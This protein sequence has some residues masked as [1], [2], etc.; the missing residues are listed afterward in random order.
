[1]KPL[2]VLLAATLVLAGCEGMPERVA[3]EDGATASAGYGRA[4]GRVHYT[5]GGKEFDWGAF[6]LQTHDLT[7]FVRPLPD[8]PMQFMP[9]EGSGAFV[10]PLRPGDYEIIGLQ[11]RTSS[12]ARS[13]RTASVVARFRVPEAG[14]AVYI[15]DL[16]VRADNRSSHVRV[17]DE[18]EG[19]RGRA[20][21]RIAKGGF[22]VARGLMELQKSQVGSFRRWEP[23]C[24]GS[25]GVSCDDTHQG[26]VPLAPE[27]TGLSFP[28]VKDGRPLLE[29][30]PAAHAD[31]TYDVAIYESFKFGYGFNGQV[32]R[33]R[34]R[35]VA[36]AENLKEPRF[37]PAEPLAPGKRYE[38]TVRARRGDVVSTWSSTRYSV[39]L[40]VAARSASGLWF[41]FET[42]D[43]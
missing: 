16:R 39:F 7:L 9:M 5:E 33:L 11:R 13:W 18:F 22:H 15:G 8:G 2:L 1:M 10:W 25:F 31:V 38:W 28:V 27:G 29:W 42:P 19:A 36:Y 35:R 37:V 41:G 3:H 17:L 14:T 6:G 26:V 24:L 21:P 40:L 34:G 12:A 4:F 43:R 32:D 20:E 30:K 23:I